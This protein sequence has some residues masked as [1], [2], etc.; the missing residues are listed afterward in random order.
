MSKAVLVVANG[1]LLAL[2][3]VA[4]PANEQYVD[5]FVE[6]TLGR[7]KLIIPN[8]KSMPGGGVLFPADK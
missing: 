3:L 2:L 4:E 5:A 1:F 6:Y 7:A 8:P